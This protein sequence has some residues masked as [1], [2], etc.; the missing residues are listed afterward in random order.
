MIKQIRLALL[1]LKIECN[2]R[3]EH[4]AEGAAHLTFVEGELEKIIEM[5]DKLTGENE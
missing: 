2:C 3:V 4:G 1:Q 5:V